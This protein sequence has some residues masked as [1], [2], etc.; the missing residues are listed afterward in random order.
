VLDLS[1]ERA[2]Y[3]LTEATGFE[4]LNTS[5]FD[6]AAAL[7]GRRM[8]LATDTAV[9]ANVP[10]LQMR[11]RSARLREEGSGKG[12]GGSG[13][14]EKSSAD[15]AYRAMSQRRRAF[16]DS[17]S[18]RVA[19]S[20]WHRWVS[21]LF[22]VDRD[23]HDGS[24]GAVDS[25]LYRRVD[26]FLNRTNAPS[27][28][29]QSAEFLE[30]ADAWD[31]AVVQRVGDELIGKTRNGEKWFSANYLRDA[32]VVAHLENGDAAGAKAAFDALL[33]LVS[34]DAEGYLR[35]RLLRA[36]ISRQLNP[37]GEREATR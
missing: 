15:S 3:L 20:D 35:T 17:T 30:A 36:Y 7:S 34:R 26:E 25:G 12:E 28:A 27:G 37:H 6:I 9:L 18:A 16:D 29:R 24:A 11:G 2:R 8:P 33:P 31:F 14:S 32:T 5:S 10:R 4:N 23:V 19:P 21:R 13:T 22:D 1:A